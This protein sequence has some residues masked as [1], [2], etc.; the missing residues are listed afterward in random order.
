MKRNVVTA[1][2]WKALIHRRRG[3]K[4]KC[5]QEKVQ[6]TMETLSISKS[7]LKRAVKDNRM[8]LME[9]RMGPAGYVNDK[10]KFMEQG[11]IHKWSWPAVD[12]FPCN[13]T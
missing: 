4:V 8:S 7:R 5:E 11:Q 12:K 2:Y 1:R 9:E 13:P 10:D 3:C 6:H